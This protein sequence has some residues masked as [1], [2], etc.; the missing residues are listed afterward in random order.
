MEFKDYLTLVAVIITALLATFTV[1]N[2]AS[3]Y[4]QKLHE[5]QLDEAMKLM[6]GIM[7][8]LVTSFYNW[9]H[10]SDLEGRQRL[11]AEFLRDISTLKIVAARSS[12][13]LP[14]NTNVKASH[15]ISEMSS[16]H[17]LLAEYMAS[18]DGDTA[19]ERFEKCTKRHKNVYDAYD[20]LIS[21]LRSEL[22]IPVLHQKYS[23][24]IKS[25]MPFDITRPHTD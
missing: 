23:D 18:N 24:F 15:L 13:V 6:E 25:N 8:I 11:L 10:K 14:E 16:A 21:S 17:F 3:P 19:K 5:K 4:K 9:T 22:N 2:S 12:V 20:E 7:K 1:W